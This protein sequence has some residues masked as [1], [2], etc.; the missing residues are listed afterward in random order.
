MHKTNN[1]DLDKGIKNSRYM[2][3]SQII[4]SKFSSIKT[5]VFQ[6]DLVFEVGIFD[7]SKVY[8]LD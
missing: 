2:N 1:D 7:K 8:K 3:Q 5:E 4:D 6:I